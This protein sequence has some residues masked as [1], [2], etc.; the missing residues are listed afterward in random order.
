[1][2]I[3]KLVAGL[4]VNQIFIIVISWILTYPLFNI[5]RTMPMAFSAI[6][7]AIYLVFMY[8]YAWNIGYRD[9]R[10]IPGY[11]PSRQVPIKVS[12]YSAILPV[13]LLLIRVFFPDIWASENPFL[14]GET[15]LIVLNCKTMGTPDFLYRLWYFPFA[16]FV[17]TGNLTAYILELFPLPIIV[18]AGYY[19]GLKRFS[20]SYFLRSKIVYKNNKDK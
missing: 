14:T 17:P 2:K 11:M 8:S 19:T 20:I 4:Y 1:M 12:L 13:L 6:T 16:A 9:A 15:D 10:K 3:F 18:F 5:A 7:S